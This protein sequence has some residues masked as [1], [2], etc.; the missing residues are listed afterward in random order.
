MSL[1]EATK[2]KL[3]TLTV[4]VLL[5]TRAAYL[6]AGANPIKHWD[7]L[8]SRMRAAARMS[9]TPEEW[10]TRLAL[11]LQLAAPSSS[12]SRALVD[13]AAAMAERG[14]AAEWLDLVERE[15][16]FL[17]AMTRLCAEERAEERKAASTKTE[18]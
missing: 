18:V 7:Q 8:Q 14:C 9:Q 10:G 12:G 17:M 1:D 13:L 6:A 3:R 16:G 2:E 4:E 5:V 11:G 15:Y